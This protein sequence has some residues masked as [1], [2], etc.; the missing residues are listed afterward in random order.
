MAH[1]AELDEN[2]VVIRVLV[3]SDNDPAGDEG[4]SWLE[5]TF[6]GRWLQTSYNCSIRKNFAGVGFTYDSELDAFIGPKPF[7]SWVLNLDDCRWHSPIAKPETGEWK[8]DE[9][10]TSWIAVVA[11]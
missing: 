8:W 9:E 3:T 1:F 11:E 2:D 6:G 5:N 7:P 10:S 4:L